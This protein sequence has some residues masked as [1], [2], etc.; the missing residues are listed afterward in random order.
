[1]SKRAVKLVKTSRKNIIK[2]RKKNFV[3]PTHSPDKRTNNQKVSDHDKG[4]KEARSAKRLASQNNP[5]KRRLI[6][7]DNDNANH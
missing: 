1:M 7:N 6:F 3:T 4:R 2:K 5:N